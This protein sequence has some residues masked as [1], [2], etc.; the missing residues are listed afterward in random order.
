MS[1]HFEAD[2]WMG[3]PYKF[4]RAKLKDVH[5]ACLEATKTALE[6]GYDVI[7]S[8]TF[9][10]KWEMEPYLALAKQVQV[11]VCQGDFGN[12]H[13]VPPCVIERMR[14]EFEY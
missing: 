4:D 3:E 13:D 9:V 14:K 2:M 12:V 6:G 11:I 7:V 5:A 1:V 8:N 10:K